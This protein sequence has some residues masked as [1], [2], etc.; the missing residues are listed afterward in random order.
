MKKEVEGVE[1]KVGQWWHNCGGFIK[2]G[3]HNPPY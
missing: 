3:Q 2:S 1:E